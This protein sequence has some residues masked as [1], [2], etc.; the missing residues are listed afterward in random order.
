M[1]GINLPAKLLDLQDGDWTDGRPV[2]ISTRSGKAWDHLTDAY[3]NQ[4][5][6][7]IVQDRL[8][9]KG[10]VV[11]YEQITSSTNGAIGKFIVVKTEVQVLDIAPRLDFDNDTGY[12]KITVPDYENMPIPSPG[13]DDFE[14]ET[15][16]MA[17]EAD[18]E[19]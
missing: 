17:M 5:E 7:N 12:T 14:D 6:I 9:I 8:L 19:G 18:L 11:D 3:R 13:F 4:E 10:K 2:Q 16:G 15:D 1:N